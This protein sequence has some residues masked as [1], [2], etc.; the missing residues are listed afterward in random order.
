MTSPGN[1]GPSPP[2]V[3]VDLNDSVCPRVSLVCI[4]TTFNGNPLDKTVGNWKAWSIKMRNNLA[5]FGLGNYIQ[6]GTSAPDAAIYPIANE[7]WRTNDAMVRGFIA[8]SCATVESELIEKAKSAYECFTALQT[9]H[10]NKRPVK[11]VNLIQNALSQR[12][13]R[14]KDQ[15][16]NCRK[17]R[18][19]IRRA[20]R[21]PGGI[22]EDIFVNITLLIILGNGHEHVRAMIQRDMQA[23]TKENPF[24][25]D[26]VMAY[27]EQ[28][29]Q[30][31][32]GDEQRSGVS[33]SAL[34]LMTQPKRGGTPS[35][36]ECSNC[37]RRGHIADWCIRPGGG[38][39]RKSIEEAQA[40][41]RNAKK[42]GKSREERDLKQKISLSGM[43]VG[44]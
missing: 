33:D 42:K 18:E 27:L 36:S 19:D 11:Q 7:N 37:H 44:P 24:S 41:Q 14:D 16:V 29:L 6:E 22:T 3:T 20:F 15:V 40:A 4:G 9:Y 38:M 34:A 2:A 30:L 1:D 39:A 32:I 5:I 28:D 8:E 12:V 31:L 26:R 35:P 23:A 43:G 13:A 10:L 25:S 17:V 21:M